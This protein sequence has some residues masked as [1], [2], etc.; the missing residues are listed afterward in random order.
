MLVAGG[1]VG[2]GLFA[3]GFLK[4]RS[5]I[6]EKSEVAKPPVAPVFF[7]GTPGALGWL[8]PAR[9]GTGGKMIFL[10]IDALRTDFVL[11]AAPAADRSIAWFDRLTVLSELA[12]REPED[13]QLF[14]FI[15]DPPTA[16]T[17]RLT[18][19]AAGTLPAFA[20]VA[21]N[22]AEASVGGDNLVQQF[23]H[24]PAHRRFHMYGDDTWLHLFPTIQQRTR[25]RVAGYHSFHLFD[26]HTVDTAIKTHLLPLL[27]QRDGAF[28]VIVAHFLGVDH[29]GHKHGPALAPCGE[30]LAEMDGVIRRVI[31]LMPP[32]TQLFVLGDHGMT[33][34]GDHGGISPKETASVLFS[35]RRSGRGAGTV[36]DAA[37]WAPLLRRLN[38]L[39]AQDL[40]LPADLFFRHTNDCGALGGSLAQ[41]DFAST[42]A[43]MAGLPIPFGNVGSI[44]PELLIDWAQYDR[45]S[46]TSARLHN[47]R[48]LVE[49]VRMN[50]H[51]VRRLLETCQVRGE[52]GFGVRQLAPLLAAL[53]AAEA[54]LAAHRDT[55]DAGAL[56]ENVF[57]AYY[58]FLRGTQAHLRRIWADFDMLAIGLGLSLGIGCVLLLGAALLLLRRR[59]RLSFCDG[60]AVLLM[61]AHALS[62]AAT[63]FVTFEDWMVRFMLTTLITVKF[64]AD[65]R[66][67]GGALG[68]S[69]WISAGAAVL[70]VRLASLSGACR[71]EQFPYCQAYSHKSL[72]WAPTTPACALI[73][74]LASAGLM[75]I[76]EDVRSRHQDAARRSTLLA[77]ILGALYVRWVGLWAQDAAAGAAHWVESLTA[78]VLPRILFGAC[79]GG[80]YVF[81]REPHMITLMVLCLGGIVQRPLAGWTQLIA[82]H[83]LLNHVAPTLFG[84]GGMVARGA[85]H[86]LVGLHLF[87]T[88]AH[89]MTLT[90]LQWEA[91][92]IGL[93]STIQVVAALLMALNTFSG[94]IAATVALIQN[95]GWHSGSLM[96]FLWYG[97]ALLMAAAS[98]TAVLMRHLQVWKMFTPRF[99][100][101]GLMM[102][103]HFGVLGIL[104]CC[105][106]H[107]AGSS[108]VSCRV[109]SGIL[110]GRPGGGDDRARLGS[111]EGF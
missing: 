4:V 68:A 60:Y 34:S 84:D 58:D 33:D 85:F 53:Q 93:R 20:E 107:P 49:A 79:L 108:R 21:A 77:L 36:R 89:Q 87:F 2:A 29:C 25:G 91:A 88:S 8:P 6:E 103:A 18:G 66:R 32:D 72:P 15:A 35:Y 81:R 31:A 97:M 5:L 10:L 9:A 1:L 59:R 12:Q 13:A 106:G 47:A 19:L 65:W 54:R 50:A 83:L 28:D 37:F 30:K 94:P 40:E 42:V 71:E 45:L 38:D 46:A 23:L 24:S 16:T 62:L 80:L 92:F 56:M 70:A 96:V 74:A 17:Q 7:A 69:S 86:Y 64:I 41:I 101:Q 3:R 99:L 11:P 44:I 76:Y 27:E 82:G 78:I 105:P 43:L 102:L 73:L 95:A 26:L 90:N 67:S 100:L 48:Y 110:Q 57:F 111:K 51:Q 52:A 39:R 61:A 22:F 98:F 14:H 109:V 55:E 63:S 104:R 75:A